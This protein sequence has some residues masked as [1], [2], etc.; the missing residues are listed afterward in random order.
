MMGGALGCGLT[1]TAIVT[2]DIIKCRKQIDPKVYKSVAD[3]FSR[4]KA[5]E[6]TSGLVVGWLPTLIGYSL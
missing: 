3:G 2:L 5:T 1:H 4:I 6:G